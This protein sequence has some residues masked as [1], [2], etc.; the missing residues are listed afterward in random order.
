MDFS[1]GQ[2]LRTST[3]W[4]I[5]GFKSGRMLRT[6]MVYSLALLRG[7]DAALTEP[8][9]K[10]CERVSSAI[11]DSERGSVGELPAGLVTDFR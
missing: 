2:G 11:E 3:A 1:I 7:I 9:L 5:G 10:G 4:R 8:N 6:E